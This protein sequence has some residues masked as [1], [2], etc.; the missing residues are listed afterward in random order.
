MTIVWTIWPRLENGLRYAQYSMLV[1][2]AFSSPEMIW[3]TNGVVTLRPSHERSAL[4]FLLCLSYLLARYCF[5][6]LLVDD[7]VYNVVYYLHITHAVATISRFRN[8]YSHASP[9]RCP[10]SRS[11]TATSPSKLCQVSDKVER[12]LRG[13]KTVCV[14]SI[15][16]LKTGVPVLET[17]V[18]E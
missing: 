3:W 8:G 12:T 7:L 14:G 11:P 9:C 4:I 13:K 15:K 18:Y 10:R 16:S 1:A 17:R 5:L 6:S 2:V